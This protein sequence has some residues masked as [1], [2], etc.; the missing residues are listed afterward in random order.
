MMNAV[1]FEF[2][3]MFRIQPVAKPL[4]PKPNNFKPGNPK[5]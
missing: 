4:S 2:V 1:V 5:P 3:V